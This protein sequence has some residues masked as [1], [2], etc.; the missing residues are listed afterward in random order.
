MPSLRGGGGGAGM[1]CPPNGCLCPHFWFTKN[2]VFGTS[3]NDKTTNSDGKIA[4][5]KSDAIIIKIFRRSPIAENKKGL[6]KF[7][8][9]FLAFSNKIS[10]VQKIMLSSSRGQGNFRGL[11]ASRPRPKT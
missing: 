3:H 9:R 4:V 8:A 7:S 2:T 11:E 6:R 10:T 5:H 1:L